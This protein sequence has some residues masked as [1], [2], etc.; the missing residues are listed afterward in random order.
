LL[1]GTTL[2][3][4][5]GP[6]TETGKFEG[7]PYVKLKEVSE[8]TTEEQTA[9][10][11]EEGAILDSFKQGTPDEQEVEK[12]KGQLFK[13]EKDIDVG[14]MPAHFDRMIPEGESFEVIDDGYP[15]NV[16]DPAIDWVKCRYD[17]KVIYVL[18]YD[19]SHLAKPGGA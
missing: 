15:G 6:R 2:Q 14:S 13:A 4:T 16:K 9:K 1:P 19:I 8:G 11:D 5:Q 7:M 3:V 12:E 10:T 17:D 18:A